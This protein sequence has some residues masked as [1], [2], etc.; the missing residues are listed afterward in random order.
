MI[1]CYP[2]MDDSHADIHDL[3]VNSLGGRL[4]SR[5]E[6]ELVKAASDELPRFSQGEIAPEYRVA[7]AEK[8]IELR[9]SP[10][11]RKDG[12]RMRTPDESRLDRAFNAVAEKY[13]RR[14]QNI[15]MLCTKPYDSENKTEQ[16]RRDL[17]R[18]EEVYRDLKMD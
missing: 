4:R 17:L 2:P 14:S 18:V 6:D 13:D 1:G 7:V 11:K 3:I 8:F 16:F 5:F 10:A 9:G 12:A 15:Q